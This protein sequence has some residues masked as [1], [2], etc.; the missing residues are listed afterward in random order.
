MVNGCVIRLFSSS[1]AGINLKI[2]CRSA[3]VNGRVLVV[4]KMSLEN[5]RGKRTM[6]DEKT[7][8][9][10][11]ETCVRPQPVDVYRADAAWHVLLPFW[12]CCTAVPIAFCFYP[13]SY[14]PRPEPDCGILRPE[15]RR[16][17]AAFIKN[18]LF[19]LFRVV[20][21]SCTESQLFPDAIKRSKLYW[22]LNPMVVGMIIFFFYGF[23]PH[24]ILINMCIIY[25]SNAVYT[26]YT[27][28]I[29]G[30]RTLVGNLWNV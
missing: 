3:L 14:M 10:F 19:L 7:I 22:N 5:T 12:V 8:I 28:G 15:A 20:S 25:L 1:T 4:R 29:S 26:H 21:I 23:Y 6:S 27:Y 17:N 11:T 30:V 24:S 9:I 13:C 16:K 18:F 2:I